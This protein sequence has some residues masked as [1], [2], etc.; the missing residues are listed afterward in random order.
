VPHL[1]SIKP[2]D[3]PISTDTAAL[4]MDSASGPVVEAQKL[5]F[6][7]IDN[8]I[9][10]V[11]GQQNSVV[12]VVNEWRCQGRLK[13]PQIAFENSPAPLGWWLTVAADQ[14]SIEIGR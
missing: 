8:R 1:W 9:C 3:R 5:R 14:C 12:R 2:L 10:G 4:A 7:M 11:G 13:I 6:L